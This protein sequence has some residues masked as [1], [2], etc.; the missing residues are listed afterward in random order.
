M[1]YT[2]ELARGYTS[3]DNTFCYLLGLISRWKRNSALELNHHAVKGYSGPFR[4][5][6]GNPRAK[7]PLHRIAWLV[8]ARIANAI[9]ISLIPGGLLL[10]WW[11]FWFVWFTTKC[12]LNLPDL[13]GNRRLCFTPAGGDLVLLCL[14]FIFP[15]SYL[16]RIPWT[17]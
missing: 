8:W 4:K 15:S 7:K 9:G 12:S 6:K 14:V 3:T 2:N 1:L 17:S 16:L 13:S 5:R 10:W 11:L